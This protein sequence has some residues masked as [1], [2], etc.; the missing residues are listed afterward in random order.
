MSAVE[1]WKE[2]V[3]THHT[4]S[5]GVQD[6]SAH[7]EDF[8]RPFAAAFKDDPFRTDDP[9]LNR[10]LREVGPD[11]TLLDVGGGAGRLAL[12]LALHCRQVTVVDPS[13]SMLE[14]LGEGAKGAGIT[15]LTIAKGQWEEVEVASADAVLCS[16]VL[17]GVADVV[18]FIK[19]LE[20]HAT[21]RVLVLMFADSPQGH[22][23]PFWKPV[24]G[25]DRVNL[26][27]M[28]E[29]L[30]VLWEM[31]IFPDLEMMAAASTHVFK[32]REKAVEQ[33]RQRLY[34]AP[35]SD[36]DRRLERAL[37]ELLIESS[38]G[39]TVR[40]AGPRRLGLVSWQPR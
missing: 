32:S 33:L 8:W 39:L 23:A 35:D 22:L 38:D 6:P 29:L 27:A 2:R 31:D 34:V 24:H 40:G 18:P 1:R 11:K 36:Q 13:D 12:P 14:Q 4:Q 21:E 5:I 28:R 15:N 30:D 19:K 17:Y 16:H 37:G 7:S 26:P 10:L 20:S 3:E 9:A 25:E